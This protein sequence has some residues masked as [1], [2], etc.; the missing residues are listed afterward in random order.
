MGAG[1]STISVQSAVLGFAD[2]YGVLSIDDELVIYTA[3]TGS[4]FTGCQRGAFG[5]AAA[6]HP[7]GATVRANMVA[8]FITALQ[9]AVVA[10]GTEL[11]TAAAR[12][13]VRKDGAVA[14]TGVK[15]F[16]DGVAV[17][18]GNISGTGL[19]RLPN[20]GAIKWRKADNSGDLGIA[21]NASDHIAMDAVIDFAATFGA[22]S[23][24]D[25]TTTSKGIVQIDSVGG[26]VVAAGVIGLAST[27]ITPGTYPKVTVDQKGRVTAGVSLVAG[28]LP[29]HTW[30]AIS[31]PARCRSRSRN[32]GTP[33]GNRRALNLI[34]NQ[35]ERRR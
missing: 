28:D 1:D 9:S 22:F 24:P 25:A 23:Y 15:T 35:S 32:N 16:Q 18:T 7:N 10:I 33:V 8:G 29:A 31:S 34:A 30:L 11:G 19:V 2:A 14:I 3:K 26:L 4:Q 6:S 20:L 21:L 17:G 13:Y 12:N 5:T 27:A